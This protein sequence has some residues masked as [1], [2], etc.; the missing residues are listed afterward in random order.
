MSLSDIGSYAS[1]ISFIFS[2]I[3]LIL[4]FYIKKQFLFKSTLDKNTAELKKLS[5]DI[6]SLLDSYENNMTEL[7]EKFRIIDVK[8][9]FLEKSANGNLLKDIKDARNKI[10]LYYK[11]PFFSKKIYKSIQAARDIK[12][13][14]SIII[15]ELNHIKTEI[16][17]GNK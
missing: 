13:S 3:T 12:I 2:L 9:R 5:S 4:L 6:S 14:I 7:D 10:M 1:I 11:K 16:K 17:V 15:E 8:F